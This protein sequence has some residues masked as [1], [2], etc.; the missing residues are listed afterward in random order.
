MG[1]LKRPQSLIH[2]LHATNAKL[3]FS[4]IITMMYAMKSMMMIVLLSGLDLV[5]AAN[6]G[7][8]PGVKTWSLTDLV[9]AANEADFLKITE[10][11]FLKMFGEVTPKVDRQKKVAAAL[12]PS[13]EKDYLDGIN[14]EDFAKQTEIKVAVDQT[15]QPMEMMRTCVCRKP[16]CK[17]CRGKTP[18]KP[19]THLANTV[20]IPE[21]PVDADGPSHSADSPEQKLDVTDPHDVAKPKKKKAGVPQWKC[22]LCTFLNDPTKQSC[23]TCLTTRGIP[24]KGDWTCKQCTWVNGP[25]D[26]KCVKCMNS[27]D[28]SEL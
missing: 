17:W 28:D 7:S 22:N 20:N 13:E 8:H 10:A 27:S 21:V 6:E 23:I 15:Y 14:E 3:S 19:W 9:T 26:Q 16:G 4:Q 5:T 11:D 24:R 18:I 2:A 25:L 12:S 1:T